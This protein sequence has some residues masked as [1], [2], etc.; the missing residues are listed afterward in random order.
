MSPTPQAVEAA[1]E[2]VRQIEKEGVLLEEYWLPIAAPMMLDLER[3]IDRAFAERLEAAD[4]ME[5][6]LNDMVA[7]SRRSH[8]RQ[9]AALAAFRKVKG[10][11]RE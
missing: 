7:T 6:V 11:Q 4:E 10:G 8:E 5:R 9:M 3:A 2:V 1:K